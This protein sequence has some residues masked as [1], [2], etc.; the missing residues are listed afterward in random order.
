MYD[1]R[2]KKPEL[3]AS[4]A[5]AIAHGQLFRGIVWRTARF[6]MAPVKST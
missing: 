1:F 6:L 3:Y 4:P 5:P 2:R